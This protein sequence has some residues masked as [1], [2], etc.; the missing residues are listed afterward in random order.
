[1][2]L[3]S[4]DGGF[5]IYA[6][7]SV[8]FMSRFW[9]FWFRYLG[10]FLFML[11]SFASHIFDFTVLCCTGRVYLSL[12]SIVHHWYFLTCES[13]NDSVWRSFDSCQL[14]VQHSRT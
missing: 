9:F 14:G 3:R 2:N 12:A 13:S 1:M 8:E 6:F 5:M 11:I 7:Y 10:G 4:Y